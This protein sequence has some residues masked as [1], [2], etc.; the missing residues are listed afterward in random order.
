M[1]WTATQK[2]W[3]LVLLQP[4]GEPRELE[5]HGGRTGSGQASWALQA[6]RLQPNMGRH[7]EGKQYK[8]NGALGN[9]RGHKNT[10]YSSPDNEFVSTVEPSSCWGHVFFHSF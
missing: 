3:M 6:L 2:N 8:G 5:P 10:K 9:L 1:P 4:L 7:P